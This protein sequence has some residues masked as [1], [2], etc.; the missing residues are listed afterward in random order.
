[1]SRGH[2]GEHLLELLDRRRDDGDEIGLAQAPLRRAVG[3]IAAR[4]AMEHRGMRGRDGRFASC[5]P[6]LDHGAPVAG[7]ALEWRCREA[8]DLRLERRELFGEILRLSIEIFI[9][10]PERA[11]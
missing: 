5:K 1:M 11:L 7:V 9:D 6:R 4:A 3:D 10:V 2:V 8:L